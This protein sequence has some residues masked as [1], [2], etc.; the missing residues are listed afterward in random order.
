MT[1]PKKKPAK[2]PTPKPAA[3]RVR[4][5][6]L[7]YSASAARKARVA[8][9]GP[10]K[11]DSPKMTAKKAPAKKPVPAKKAPAKKPVPPKKK[12]AVK[13][14]VP[15]KK[16]VAVKKP[17]PVKKAPA[18]KPVP[19]KKKAEAKKPVPVKKAPAKKPVPPKKKAEAKKPVPV[20]KAPAK[21]P[22]PPKKKTEAKKPVPAPK[23]VAPKPG[24]PHLTKA[25]LAELRAVM[26]EERAK[27]AVRTDS[28]KRQSLTRPDEENPEE[29]GTDQIT[30]VTELRKADS[31]SARM[32]QIDEALRAIDR[33]DYGLC[34]NCGAKIPIGRLRAMPDA[35]YCVPCQEEFDRDG[36]G[37]S[38]WAQ[39][40]ATFE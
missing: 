5:P 13:K 21:K 6:G 3:T 39:A 7:Q 11:K 19:P 22:V 2:K 12:V 33:G 38:P 36:A 15:P 27:F 29:A 4:L 40:P 18:K 30:I 31:G 20:K 32:N 9:A 17:V 14:P 25:E 23:P 26:L 1:A 16:K 28:L 34:Q 24:K 37:R 10:A 35:K 8:A